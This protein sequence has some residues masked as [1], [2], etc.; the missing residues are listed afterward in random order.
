MHGMVRTSYASQGI[1]FMKVNDQDQICFI[2]DAPEHPIKQVVQ[3]AS[4]AN[5]VASMLAR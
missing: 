5:L 2:M 1:T 4:V 3:A